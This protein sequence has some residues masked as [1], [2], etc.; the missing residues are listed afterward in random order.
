MDPTH[1]RP[2]RGPHRAC[3]FQ[4]LNGDFAIYNSPGTEILGNRRLIWTSRR[5][6]IAKTSLATSWSH[7]GWFLR[8]LKRGGWRSQPSQYAEGEVSQLV[9]RPR[10]TA[11]RRGDGVMGASFK[12]KMDRLAARRVNIAIRRRAARGARRGSALK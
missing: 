11:R 5:Y 3:R 12:L 2:L 9:P 1:Q 10:S 4:S 7:P 8:A 6:K